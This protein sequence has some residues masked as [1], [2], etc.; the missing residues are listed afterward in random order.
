MCG[1]VGFFDPSG[2]N[3][4][5]ASNT[6]DLMSR[7]LIHRGPDGKGTWKDSSCGIAFA[8]QRLSILDLSSAG[9]QPMVSAS[10]RYV[11]TFNGE[12]YNHLYIR[13]QIDRHRSTNWRG[14]SD[15]ETL[16]CAIEL[17][18]VEHALKESVGMFAFGLWDRHNLELTL[19][20]D[21]MG[22]KPLYYGWQGEVFLFGS[23]LKALRIHPAFCNKVQRDVLPLYFRHGY[24][25]APWS[26]WQGIRKLEP[27]SFLS[28]NSITQRD[29]PHPKVYWSLARSAAK[30]QSSP[31]LGSEQD[32]INGL[33][34]VL[35]QSITGQQIADVP[36]GAFLSGGIDSTTVVALMQANSKSPVKTFTIGF[37]DTDFNEAD[38]AKAVAKHLG[39]D[40][41]ELFVTAQGA[42]DVIPFLANTYDEPFGDSSAIPTLLLSRLASS[43]VSVSLSGDG[44]D[45]LFG[46]YSRYSNFQLWSKRSSHLPGFARQAIAGVI[47]GFKLF[48]SDQNR[49]RMEMLGGIFR[50]NTHV[51]RY[52]ALN[53][54]W[55]PGDAVCK[56]SNNADY[57][58]NGRDNNISLHHPLDSAMLADSMTYLPDNILVKVDRAAMFASLETRVPMLDH[59]VVEWA[60]TLPQS[61]KG[62]G[63]HDKWVLRQLLYRYVPK[64][65]MERPKRGF[66]VPIGAW[67]RGPLRDWAEYLLSEQLIH[68]EGFLN[69]APIRKKWLE[70]L[71][72]QHNWEFHLWDVLMFQA[73]LGSIKGEL[74]NS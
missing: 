23:E 43:K 47:E 20:R 33:E 34:R 38:Y 50:A 9:H 29:M 4:L 8:H 15:T 67:L 54:H 17:W 71:S 28:I 27:G 56:N 37:D 18:G 63:G 72:G 35:Q 64:E 11:I 2:F 73:W 40:H 57:W 24:I 53:S 3:D 59:R 49:R 10:G 39:T 44:G 58:F 5:E 48:Q 65:L 26:V 30:S 22:E 68:Q 42:Q 6:L 31:F 14:L 36:V 12:I 41:N 55:L 62:R 21:R 69:A 7:S 32:A 60:W 25:P 46:G 61:F 13:S 1:I 52:L 66:G 74:E 70:H 19:A 16:L 51:Q 45:E